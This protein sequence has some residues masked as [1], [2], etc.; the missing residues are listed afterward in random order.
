VSNAWIIYPLAGD[1]SSKGGLIP[2]NTA[3]TAVE[4]SKVASVYKLPL[5]DE[6]AYH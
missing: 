1:N 2:D 3:F 6:S 4:Q 5:K